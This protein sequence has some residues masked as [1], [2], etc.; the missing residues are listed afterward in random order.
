MDPVWSNV[1]KEALSRGIDLNEHLPEEV[2]P[3][4]PPTARPLY[5]VYN[6]DDYTV[7]IS[8]FDTLVSLVNQH[9]D[10]Y[11]LNTYVVEGLCH[12]DPHVKTSLQYHQSYLLRLCNFWTSAFGLNATRC[13]L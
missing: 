4:G 5:V 12:G 3:R 6:K 11:E 10:K 1:E 9:P 2:L 8:E 7:P 13:G